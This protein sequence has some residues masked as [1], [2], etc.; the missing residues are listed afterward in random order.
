MQK[1][2][3]RILPGGRQGDGET[4]RRGDEDF[5]KKDKKSDI[6]MEGQI[7]SQL[8]IKQMVNSLF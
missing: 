7:N 6:W 5:K 1:Q 8:K 4:G 3:G 2:K